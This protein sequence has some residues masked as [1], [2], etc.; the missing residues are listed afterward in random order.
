VQCNERRD[1]LFRSYEEQTR[2]VLHW[3]WQVFCVIE[4]VMWISLPAPVVALV[5]CLWFQLESYYCN[6]NSLNFCWWIGR[7]D[8]DTVVTSVFFVCLN[9]WHLI[10]I[11]VIFWA[12]KLSQYGVWLRAGRDRAIEV[13]SPAEAKDFSSSLHIQTGSGAHPASYTGGPFSG[14][15]ARPGR[16]TDHSPPSGAENEL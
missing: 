7:R 15:K 8:N 16:D 2:G 9:R 6:K 4:A 3:H 13:R 11:Q 12:G 14:V 5:G 10:C 1:N